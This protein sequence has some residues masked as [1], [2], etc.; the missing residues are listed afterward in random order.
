MKK[1]L[2]RCEKITFTKQKMPPRIYK[3]E[4][5]TQL[6][7][8]RRIKKSERFYWY[9]YALQKKDDIYYVYECEIAEDNM[10]QELYE[11]E[12]IHKYS[13]LDKVQQEFS[14]KYGIRFDD[15]HV[16]KGKKLFNVEFYIGD[17]K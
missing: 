4:K 2:E 3:I 17:H 8:E 14:G 11:Y 6:G 13:S 15:I 1:E 9:S 10:A 7:I 5:G 12:N 16:L